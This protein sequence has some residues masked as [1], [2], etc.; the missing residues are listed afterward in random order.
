MFL[1]IT[2]LIF[3]RYV[4]CI[5]STFKHWDS[6]GWFRILSNVITFMKTYLKIRK[7]RLSVERSYL[8]FFLSRLNRALM[9]FCTIIIVCTG[10]IRWLGKRE[11]EFVQ[12]RTGTQGN[13]TVI[14]VL[15]YCVYQYQYILRWLVPKTLY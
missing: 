5:V 13:K 4:Q 15:T 2:W 14:P 6:S 3:K 10:W 9:R 12:S 1:T 7:W 8:E 11:I